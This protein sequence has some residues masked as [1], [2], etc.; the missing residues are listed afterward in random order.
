MRA[1]RWLM[2]VLIAGCVGSQDD[3]SQ[4]HDLRVLGVEMDP[5]EMMLTPP[6]GTSCFTLFAALAQLA[7]GGGGDAGVDLA[8]IAPFLRPVDMTWLIEDPDGGGRDISYDV[9]A[10]SDT[11]DLTCR[12][13]GGFVALTSGTTQAGELEY[14]NVLAAQVVPDGGPLLIG[15]FEND[16]YKGLGGIRV[17][18]VIHLTAGD[19][20]IYAQKL[21]V[22][23]CQ[24]F[25]DMMAN[26]Q[27][28]LPGMTVNGVEMPDAGRLMLRGTDAPLM[29][30]PDDFTALQEQY[31]EPSFDLKEVHLVESWKVSYYATV[32]RFGSA[33][34]GGTDFTGTTDIQINQWH[35][36]HDGGIPETDV[37]FWFVVRDGR[38]GESW[39]QRGAHYIP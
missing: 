14:A 28:V 26:Q 37:D 10:C 35:P 13:D 31:V 19:E 3:P 24:A 30:A 25:P 8:L 18:V 6:M 21:M 15:A 34:L 11:S 22:Y 38:G 23:S 36:G 4:V 27:P 17:P 16:P 9:S 12:H 7:G 39:I 29:F 33:T 20:E 1:R 2:A 32:G 5:P